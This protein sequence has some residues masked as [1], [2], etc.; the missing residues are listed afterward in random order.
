MKSFKPEVVSLK[1]T[2]GLNEKWLQDQ[3]QADPSI[4]GLGHALDCKAREHIQPGA[5]RLDLLLQDADSDRWYEVEIQLGKTD[6][7]P[8]FGQ[9]STGTSRSSVT[10][11][12]TTAL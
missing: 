8:L 12:S 7:S 10:R 11:T 6:E 4:L 2:P 1:N 5:G 3:I 9:S